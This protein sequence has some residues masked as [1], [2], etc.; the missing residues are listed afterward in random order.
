MAVYQIPPPTL[1]NCSSGD[2]GNNWQLFREAYEDYALATELTEKDKMIQVAT[3]KSVMGLDCKK[4][5]NNIMIKLQ[6]LCQ[7]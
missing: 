7:N 1:M 2:L 4:V 5:L 6:S 3:L